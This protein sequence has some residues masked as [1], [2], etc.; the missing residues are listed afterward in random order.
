M[1][2]ESSP[3]KT[4]LLPFKSFGAVADAREVRIDLGTKRFALAADEVKALAGMAGPV[5]PAR[6]VREGG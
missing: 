1:T 4:A 6:P 3:H 2:L 5:G